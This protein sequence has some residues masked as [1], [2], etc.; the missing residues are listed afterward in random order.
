[1]P[2]EKKTR[3][4]AY[5]PVELKHAQNT[6]CCHAATCT[7]TKENLMQVSH[8]HCHATD[9][10]THKHQQCVLTAVFS[11]TATMVYDCSNPT[12]HKTMALH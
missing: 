10:K 9:R 8:V 7:K 2:E 5:L 4:L 6:S 3:C 1:M 11:L 12:M